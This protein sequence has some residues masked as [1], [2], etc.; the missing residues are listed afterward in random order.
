MHCL[1]C[2]CIIFLMI[3]LKTNHITYFLEIWGRLI[4]HNAYR[5][6]SRVVRHLSPMAYGNEW[7]QVGITGVNVYWALTLTGC[8]SK[9]FICL[10]SFHLNLTMATITVAD[11]AVILS[12]QMRKLKLKEDEYLANWLWL[13]LP[14]TPHEFRVHWGRMAFKA[15]TTLM[16][17][18]WED[19]NCA[20]EGGGGFQKSQRN[21]ECLVMK[22]WWGSVCHGDH[23]QKSVFSP[24][25]WECQGQVLILMQVA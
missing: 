20:E 2:L 22:P 4:E 10:G 23:R 11:T 1:V 19:S 15:R 17:P 5:A 25:G 21:S 12:L 13:G 18:K 3:K 8:C 9:C 24:W 14:P 7:L 6:F 16:C